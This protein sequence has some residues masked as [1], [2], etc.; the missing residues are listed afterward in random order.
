MVSNYIGWTYR[1]VFRPAL[2]ILIETHYFL[3]DIS[4][5]VAQGRNPWLCT[6]YLAYDDLA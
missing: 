1:S 3:R 2:H 5:V 4:F 6:L